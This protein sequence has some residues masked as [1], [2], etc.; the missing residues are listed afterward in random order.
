MDEVAP[1]L[2]DLVPYL[3]RNLNDPKVSDTSRCSAR[4]H[5]TEFYLTF[6]FDSLWSVPSHAGPSV[7]M[8]VGVL[9]CWPPQMVVNC[10]SSQLLKD[11]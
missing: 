2:P 10:S 6:T 11:C 8:L 9:M 7:A 3:V 4:N 1:H 5:L